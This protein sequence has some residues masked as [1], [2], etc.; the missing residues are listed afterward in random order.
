MHKAT[1]AFLDEHVNPTHISVLETKSLVAPILD[2]SA[3]VDAQCAVLRRKMLA[4][5]TAAE[6]DPVI[7]AHT[8]A[9]HSTFKT[10]RE[11]VE[12]L[13][14]AGREVANA[15]EQMDRYVQQVKD[16]VG[17][18]AIAADGTANGVSYR[19]PR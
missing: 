16:L 14:E 12:K 4:I 10:L 1:E 11:A 8:E 5:E 18:S 6:K 17:K 3:A 2:L 9:F 19:R 15:G 7:A 13:I